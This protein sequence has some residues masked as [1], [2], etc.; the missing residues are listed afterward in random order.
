MPDF[1]IEGVSAAID[2]IYRIITGHHVFLRNGAFNLKRV[3]ADMHMDSQEANKCVSDIETLLDD[4]N[5]HILREEKLVFPIFQQIEL[6]IL[7]NNEA[8]VAACEVMSPINQAIVDHDRYRKELESLMADCISIGFDEL[9][10]DVKSLSDYLLEHIRIE[11]EELFPM[12]EN[13]C[14]GIVV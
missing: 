13:L 10:E 1:E 14:P 8:R 2:L 3:I 12:V 4:I 11:E 9:K 6:S 7:T 5:D